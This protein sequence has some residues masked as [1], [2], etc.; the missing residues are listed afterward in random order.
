MESTISIQG[1]LLSG[2]I[3]ITSFA[4]NLAKDVNPFL[5]T[6]PPAW[7]PNMPPTPQSMASPLA[8][9]AE[10]HVNDL[11]ATSN[12]RKGHEA[13]AIS[14]IPL[15]SDAPTS[16]TQNDHAE[17][18]PHKESGNPYVSKIGILTSSLPV[19]HNAF[20]AAKK[21]DAQR[22][23][24][25][26]QGEPLEAR[27]A[28]MLSNLSLSTGPNEQSSEQQAETIRHLKP[29]S[30]STIQLQNI[31]REAILQDGGIVLDMK[32]KNK[33]K[34]PKWQFGIRSRNEPVDAI[35]CLYKALI[36]MGD[37]QW[38]INPPDDRHRSN[39][40]EGPATGPFPVT[41]Q[42]ATHLPAAQEHLSESPEKEKHQMR[43]PPPVEPRIQN[44]KHSSSPDHK[45][46]ADGFTHNDSKSELDDEDVDPNV[47]P[48][49]YTPKDPW[50]I[51][52]RW[53]KK[54][55]SP[56]GVGPSTSA[57]SSVVDLHGN[58]SRRGSLAMNSLGSAVGSGIS[59]G[60][61]E[62]V[63]NADTACF[64]YLDLQIYVL[65]QDVYLVDFKNSGYEPIVGE[66]KVMNEKGEMITELVGSGHRKAEKEVTSPQPFLDL[67]NKL[68]IHLA[69]GTQ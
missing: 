62:G 7:A 28:A 17:T 52:V 8:E 35:K 46:P 19:Y 26:E 60:T 6:S 69:K 11:A 55:M 16:S 45:T 48:E 24:L 5:A 1:Q 4:A 61:P 29:H 43:E 37:C 3:L 31:T 42:G 51:K 21:D 44:Q 10:S 63:I 20:M 34:T 59:I 65:E 53:E 23:R 39:D 22:A 2:P 47:I 25:Q 50:C 14:P 58:E 15:T 56:P 27:D 64:V 33:H 68:V 38:Q 36:S 30:R 40:E 32:A 54:G 13:P 12:I 18:S 67:A 41:V 57:Q 49:G 66:R 9:A